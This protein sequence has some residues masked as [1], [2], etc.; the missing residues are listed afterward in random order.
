MA[1]ITVVPADEVDEE[2]RAAAQ[3]WDKWDSSTFPETF[4]FSYA[5]EEEVLIIKGRATLTPTTGGDPV[6]IAAGDKVVFHKGFKC[7]WLVEEAMEKFYH[8]PVPPPKIACDK[9]GVECWEESYFVAATEQDICP[10]CKKTRDPE[11]R[12]AWKDAERQKH[13]EP[14]VDSEDEAP[15]KKRKT[16]KSKAQ[17]DKAKGRAKK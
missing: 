3:K 4:D 12:R 16:A 8:Y 17:L 10:T 5:E 2:F 14:W 11:D 9:C 7:K 13:G 6:V 15:K 1:L